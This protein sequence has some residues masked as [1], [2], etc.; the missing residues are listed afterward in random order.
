MTNVAYWQ[1][2]LQKS[3]CGTEDKFSGQYTLRSNNDLSDYIIGDELTGDF[4]NDL[5]ATSIGDRGP[6][7]LFARN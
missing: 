6:F 3:F 4:G 5:E 2:Q 1:I 7:G